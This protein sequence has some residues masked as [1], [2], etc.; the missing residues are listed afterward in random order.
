MMLVMAA[1]DPQGFKVWKASELKARGEQ[2]AAKMGAEKSASETLANYGNYNTML[3]HREVSGG[4]ELHEKM[5]DLFVIQSG[6]A[7]VVVGGAITD[8]HTTA[9]G[10][11]RGTTITG[12]ASHRVSVGDVVHIPANTP[13]QMLVDAGHQVTY[14]VVKVES[15]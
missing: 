6:E 13:H 14:F 10:E 5:A 1:G 12:G 15:R 3:A 7:T 11:V 4:A 2:L 8:R 9:P